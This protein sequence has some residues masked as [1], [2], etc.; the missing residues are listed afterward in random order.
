MCILAADELDAALI[1]SIV[2]LDDSFIDFDV[3]SLANSSVVSA[4]VV[5]VVAIA[6]LLRFFSP[7]KLSRHSV[8]IFSN[9]SKDFY[10]NIERKII[11]FLNLN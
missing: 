2:C 8:T 1:G 3:S 5:A 6:S 7:N 11:D 9:S 10:F 4:I